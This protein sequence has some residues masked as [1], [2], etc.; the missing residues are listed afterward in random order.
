[1]RT[2]MPFAPAA[3]PVTPGS[4]GWGYVGFEVVCL[5]RGEQLER[6]TERCEHCLVAIGGQ[7][8]INGWTLGKRQ[9]PFE[10][11]PEAAYF[12]PRS[13][14]Q[15]E[16]LTNV[17]VA[18]CSAPAE[19]GSEARPL[20]EPSLVERGQGST[21]RRIYNILMEDQP[22]EHLLV[23]EVLTPGGNWSSYPPHKHDTEDLPHETY[24]EET[25]Y[26]RMARPEGFAIQRIYT[27]DGSLD[28]TLTVRDRSVV[29][30]P[31]GYHPVVA[32][33]GYDLYYLNVMAGPVRRWLIRV[34]PAHQ[35]LS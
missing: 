8:R 20:R 29:L 15:L 21:F 17:E 24:L 14:W 10:G 16:A 19:V 5:R 9:T 23:T 22:A 7:L 34:D 18:I 11:P 31:R 25:Y 30:V 33:A 4:A 28:E 27:D 3:K 26:Y 6:A 35:W 12:P 32:A 1:V 2:R 13:R